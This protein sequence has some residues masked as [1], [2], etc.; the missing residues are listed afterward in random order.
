MNRLAGVT[1]LFSVTT[2]VIVVAYLSLYL[3]QMANFADDPGVG[4]HLKTGEFVWSSGTPPR[5]DPFLA[6]ERRTWIADQ[7][8]S[9]LVFFVGYRVGGWGLLYKM[10]AGV[11]LVTFFGILFR[12]VRIQVGSVLASLVTVLLAF[13]CA[14]VHFIL[15]PVVFS[16]LCFASA[17]VVA[18]EFSRRE[19]VPARVMVVPGGFLVGLFALWSNVHPAFVLGLMIVLTIPIARMLDGK[20]RRDEFLSFTILALLCVLG[21]CLNPYGMVLHESI[22]ALGRSSYFLSL[23]SEWLPPNL[24]SFEGI[25]LVTFV[26]VPIVALLVSPAFRGRIG[27]FDLLSSGF[28]AFQAFGSVRFL[29]FAAIACAFPF[30]IALRSLAEE[31]GGVAVMRLSARCV[32]SLEQREKQSFKGEITAC[33]CAVLGLVF[34]NLMPLPERL[35]PQEARYPRAIAEV[36]RSDAPEGVVLASPDWGG[37]LTAN[38]Y[39][40]FKAVIDDRNTL[41]GEQ[42]YREYFQS[43]E[44][45]EALSALVE[46]FHVTH[47]IIPRKSPVG[48][49]LAS[50]TRWAILLDDGKSLVV[51]VVRQ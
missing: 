22:V 20:R 31:V 48:E 26:T 34:S 36:L 40:A 38:L 44:S 41:I 45:F 25:M 15:R 47:L 13:K 9:D 14:Q 4:W 49:A 17:F 51:R 37:F 7:W 2:V 33:C 42:L 27:W 28:L 46:R 11:W 39:P 30:A 1:R 29:P 50:E 10:L 19:S 24:E 32:R 3:L 18:R 12:A 5:V 23:N 21:S 8:L 6:T 35:G 16:V 43:L